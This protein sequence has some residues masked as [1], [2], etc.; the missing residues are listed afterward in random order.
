MSRSIVLFSGLNSKKIKQQITK[1]RPVFQMNPVRNY[2]LKLWICP[3]C[4]S[5]FPLS[6]YSD[7]ISSARIGH[8]L[9]LCL[10]EILASR[11]RTLGAESLPEF[12]FLLSNFTNSKARSE[13]LLLMPSG[14][15]LFFINEIIYST[16]G[17][18]L[19]AMALRLSFL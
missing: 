13:C 15:T 18:S 6:I 5:R 11:R 12:Y 10:L 4:F 9:C 14:V 8:P 2:N 16:A 1:P 19:Q 17:F 7:R 3:L